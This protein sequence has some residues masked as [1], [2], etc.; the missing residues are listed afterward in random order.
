M[1]VRMYIYIYIY[2]HSPNLAY[3]PDFPLSVHST[4]VFSK[5]IFGWQV[6]LCLDNVFVAILFSPPSSNSRI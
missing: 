6:L 5:A 4:R 3:L 1:Y 2:L